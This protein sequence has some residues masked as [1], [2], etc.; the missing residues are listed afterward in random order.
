MGSSAGDVPGLVAAVRGMGLEVDDAERNRALQIGGAVQLVT[1]V[2]GL[3]SALITALAEV[4]IAHALYASVRERTREIGVL[5][6]VGAT[7]GDVAALLL[8]EAAVMGLCGGAAGWGEIAR[9]IGGLLG[10][11]VRRVAA[12]GG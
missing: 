4:N 3:L 7:R 5:R 6:S 1:A 2:L 9:E 10:R 11:G 12:M 8:A